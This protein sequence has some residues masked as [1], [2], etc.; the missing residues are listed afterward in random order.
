MQQASP[1]PTL[2]T[3]P[4]P[5]AVS[6]QSHHLSLGK[7]PP[8]HRLSALRPPMAETRNPVTPPKREHRHHKKSQ[9]KQ[10]QSQRHPRK[11]PEKKSPPPS[12]GAI[13]SLFSCK[14]HHADGGGGGGK[15]C[16]KTRC[17]GSLCSSR[18]SS[19][20][21]Q[22]PETPSP[23]SRKK[24]AGAGGRGGAARATPEGTGAAVSSSY[25][26]LSSSSVTVGSSSSSSSVGG[27]FRGLRRLSGCYECHMVVDPIGGIGRD[28]SLR[29]ISPCP[30]CGEIF[31]KSES[32]EL[33]Q[34]VRH[35]GGF[36]YIFPRLFLLFRVCLIR[37]WH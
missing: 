1:P 12:W 19:R 27:S 32:L 20:V 9:G 24:W 3:P 14:H 30:N 6:C 23:E 22:R 7:H 15:K 37:Y 11:A 34:A 28:S 31:M 8:L 13:K 4:P 18:D 25:S 2:L 35:A 29:T 26:S 21:T 36:F 33:H 16:R 17:S 5:T 10:G